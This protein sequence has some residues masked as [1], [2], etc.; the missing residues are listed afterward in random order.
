MLMPS[1]LIITIALCNIILIGL[2]DKAQA[3]YDIV[4]SV[5]TNSPSVKPHYEHRL[6]SNWH[7]L[8][9][10]SPSVSA[11]PV[12]TE[13][14]ENNIVSDGSFNT[15]LVIG[16]TGVSIFLLALF[17][18]FRKKSTKR[19]NPNEIDDDPIFTDASEDNNVG[20]SDENKTDYYS[21][22]SVDVAIPK[23]TNLIDNE[24]MAILLEQ[25][26]LYE[27]QYTG[28]LDKRTTIEHSA[29]QSNSSVQTIKG[30]LAKIGKEWRRH[31]LGELRK[32][33]SPLGRTI[34]QGIFGVLHWKLLFSPL[35]QKLTAITKVI[36]G[37]IVIT[38]IYWLSKDIAWP[39]SAETITSISTL[40]VIVTAIF[41][42]TVPLFIVV[43]LF[44]NGSKNKLLVKKHLS[45]FENIRLIH[46]PLNKAT[47]VNYFQGMTV[48][49]K[50]NEG[51][52]EPFPVMLAHGQEYLKSEVSE[53]FLELV[54]NSRGIALIDVT[55]GETMG[56]AVWLATNHSMLKL[57]GELMARYFYE[58]TDKLTDAIA[59][60]SEISTYEIERMQINK[61][62]ARIQENL[63]DLD[64]LLKVWS[65]ISVNNNAFEFLIRRIYLFLNADSSVPLGIL[66]HGADGNGKKFLSR[67][68]AK[69]VRL[70]FEQ[71][72]L[73]SLKTANDV[74]KFW[75]KQRGKKGVL[76][77]ARHA[78]ILFPAAGSEHE[79]ANS[80][81]VIHAWVNE[82]KKKSPAESKV[83]VVLSAPSAESL[84]S[85]IL[86][87]I[88]VSKLEISSP[89]VK[90]RKLIL[91]NAMAA[92]S[93]QG[94]PPEFAI[95]MTTGTNIIELQELIAELKRRNPSNEV[96]KEDWQGALKDVRGGHAGLV[97]ITKTWDRLVLPH[98]LIKRLKGV[99]NL[100]A[101]LDKYKANK[102]EAPK[103]ILLFGP[104]GT[105][106]TEI[107]RTLANES[108]LYFLGT[109]VSDF[110]AQYT[111]QSSSK[112][113]DIFALARSK[114]PSILFIDEIES[115]APDRKSTGGDA[116]TGDIVTQMLVEMEGVTSSDK[117]VFVLAATNIPEAIDKAIL[118]RFGEQIE[119]GLP[120]EDD[121]KRILEILIGT[122]VQSSEFDIET[123]SAEVAKL[124]NGKSGRD[125]KNFVNRVVETEAFDTGD[126]SLMDLTSAKF[127]DAANSEF[128]KESR[129]D[130]SK[131][132]DKLILQT[133]TKNRLQQ[134]SRLLQQSEQL[135]SKGYDA[136]KGMLLFGPPGTGK[137]EIARTLAN[138]SNLPFLSA[139]TTEIKGIHIGESAR[140]VADM[141]AKARTQAPCILFLDE[142]EAL[143]AKR[144]S[145]L[146]DQYTGEIVNQ[147]LQEIDGV[148]NHE[149]TV[150]LLG[151]TNLPES[152]DDAIKSRFSDEIEI[153]LP[154]EANRQVII[155]NL[156]A[157]KIPNMQFNPTLAAEQLAPI[158]QNKSGR[159]IKNFVSRVAESAILNSGS[160]EG[161]DIRLEDLIEAASPK[162]K[163][164]PDAEIEKIWQ[165]VILPEDVKSNILGKLRLFNNADPAAP[166]GLLLYGPPGTGKTEIARKLSLSASC[167]FMSLT[168][169][170]FKAGYV[171]QSGQRVRKIW[172]QARA[173]GRCVMFID[174]CEGIFA[175]RG[176]ENSDSASEEI[177][178]A[179]L[180][181]WDGMQTNEHVK[182]WV[183]GATNRVELLDEAIVSRF[184]S[185]QEIALP[186]N[187]ARQVILAL[188]LTKLKREWPVPDS[189]SGLTQGF[190]GRK[191]STLAKDVVLNASAEPATE[192][193]WIKTT[194]SLIVASGDTVNASASW[195][196]LIL[197][198]SVKEKLQ[199]ICKMLQ[200]SEVMSAQGIDLPRG[201]ILYGPPGTGKTQIARTL[202]KESNLNF[203][204]A[205][206][207]DLKAG[208]VGQS[209]QKVKAIFE[210]ARSSAPSIL[211]IDEIEAVAK[212]RDGFGSDS[213]TQEIV[214][215]LLQEMDGAKAQKGHV[216]VLAA[217][218]LIDQ[219]DAA[220]LSRLPE[221]IEIPLPNEEQRSLM[222]AH[223][224]MKFKN[225]EFDREQGAKI[226][227]AS[228]GDCSGR[229]IRSHIEMAQQSAVKRAL[230][231]GTQDSIVI[232]L[233]DF[234]N[235]IAD[236]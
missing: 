98:A 93:L 132:W 76:I 144:G 6:Y 108:G 138:E 153:P 50:K 170:D 97:D 24:K 143:A 196:S 13:V 34:L 92:H 94:E 127:I 37:L 176:S 16:V 182:V 188:E 218:N 195:E 68:I 21:C 130:K 226:L 70:K 146:S 71:L 121:R 230:F 40:I 114:A 53:H 47:T 180:A 164:V 179:F 41:L 152:I 78:E 197:S 158:F 63:A 101:N 105:G 136:P 8:L 173:R 2:I 75:G 229:E 156:L 235:T 30:L 151:A 157:Q 165:G 194:E 14:Q 213:F 174:E 28:L 168:L 3:S 85:L 140:N 172:E 103:G 104:P 214:T 55:P 206:T 86:R 193:D 79:D 189:I 141:F 49:S 220:V 69:S 67:V 133:E 210:R 187:E 222:I 73:T 111:G 147:L 15:T 131:T 122:K 215:Q 177:V 126:P 107:A 82:W 198:P 129:R 118:S 167:Y 66:L 1:R 27:Q 112:V 201:M 135:K 231:E 227:A 89:D 84:H 25:K 45:N 59:Y 18:F 102:V 80:K 166:R 202:A 38:A 137:T 9:Q 217:T 116:F 161:I 191:L 106:K 36:L 128:D 171:G 145:S 162:G 44:S 190:S 212:S 148:K 54:L 119:I 120:Q 58:P 150:F 20:Q 39:L 149:Q 208:F 23:N 117:P 228:F 223:F 225:L 57:H 19:H 216:F 17:L 139:T 109:G 211:F 100:L 10:E 203:I 56:K 4:A 29:G 52:S 95:K 134:V 234:S 163:V 224:L 11:P 90:G 209:G 96:T 175:R 110:K 22:D 26:K 32:S 205:S 181:E 12:N 51:K 81:D 200:H 185:Q 155:H 87:E 31:L 42:I 91:A 48:T 123:T 74:Q 159:D 221:K 125:L 72:D 184:G 233:N 113:R 33:T 88:G 219:I 160:V 7:A 124:F 204:A 35:F 5:Q 46:R 169:P 77:F 186:N 142:L 178:Q 232:R 192:S 236:E 62:L 43:F 65:G 199:T 60:M 99:T 61:Q 83:W 115:I 183:V 154:N 64:N 207:A